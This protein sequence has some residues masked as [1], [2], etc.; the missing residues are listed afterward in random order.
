MTKKEQV[1][2][3]VRELRHVEGILVQL[4]SNPEVISSANKDIMHK[5]ANVKVREITSDVQSLI[6]EYKDL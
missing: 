2:T 4:I 3:V 1:A 6:A 5:F